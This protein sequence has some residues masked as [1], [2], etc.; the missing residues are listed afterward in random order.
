MEGTALTSGVYIILNTANGKVYV[1]SSTN[2]SV[3]LRN[4][5]RHLIEGTHG[6]LHLQS[7][8][9]KYGPASFKFKVVALCEEMEL[10]DEEQTMIDAL[11]TVDPAKGYNGRG[12]GPRGSH[13]PG[14][15]KKLRD[16]N[17]GKKLLSQT[18][19]KM[20]RSHLGMKTLPE[21]KEKLR[22]AMARRALDPEYNARFSAIMQSSWYREKLSVA[23]KG[24]P[25]SDREREAI[26]AVQRTPECRAK[27]SMAM[28]GKPWS[29]I[30]RAAF[31]RN[32][33]SLE[34]RMKMSAAHRGKKRPRKDP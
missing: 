31:L 26:T 18:R 1:G 12:A 6:N 7:S 8:W 29:H 11:R 24:V 5:R 4:H 27:K 9:D 34:T 2:V 30:R 15:R 22:F 16:A 23:G 33:T 28:K 14:A 20:R 32:P 25:W 17:L 13:G 21:T 10:L 19:E 3:R